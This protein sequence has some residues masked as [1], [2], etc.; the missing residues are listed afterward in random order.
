M[1]CFYFLFGYWCHTCYVLTALTQQFYFMD[2]KICPLGYTT[3]F[4]PKCRMSLIPSEL[5]ILADE[6]CPHLHTMG[7]RLQCDRSYLKQRIMSMTHLSALDQQSLH[8]FPLGCTK[9]SPRSDHIN[10]CSALY[11]VTLTFFFILMWYLS[12]I[13]ICT[14]YLEIC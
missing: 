7:I 5:N 9:L 13:Y 12:E 14:L 6:V 4:H 1:F 3:S 11:Y 10:L 2:F 8:N